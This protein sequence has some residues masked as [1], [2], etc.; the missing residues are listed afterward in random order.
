MLIFVDNYYETFV[1][2]YI[3]SL[4]LKLPDTL[5]SLAPNLCQLQHLKLASCSFVLFLLSLSKSVSSF[6]S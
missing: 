3:W 2:D 5:S 4:I 6:R 1:A